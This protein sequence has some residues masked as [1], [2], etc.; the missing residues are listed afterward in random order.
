MHKS[1]TVTTVLAAAPFRTAD[2]A[3]LQAAADGYR[4]IFSTE[5]DAAQLAQAEVILGDVPPALLQQAP[6]LQWLQLTSAGT[7]AWTQTGSLPPEVLLTNVS[8]AFGQA[9]SEYVLALI[10]ML[11]KKLHLYR[12]SQSRGIWQDLGPQASPVGKRVLIAGAGDIGC[13]VARILK[14]FA[15]HTVGIRRVPRALPPEFDEMDTLEGLDRQLPLADI[16]VCALPNTPQ[17]RGLFDRRRLA[18]LRPEALL[19]NVG[20]G[21]LIDCDAL[22]EQLEAGALAGAALDVTSPEPL[23]P[24]HPLWRCP[25]CIITPHITGGSFGH[26][27]VTSDI[28]CEICC[29]NL[30]HFAA[31]EPLRNPVDRQTGYRVTQT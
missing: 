2:R 29:E 4:F 13:A 1:G 21:N 20:R 6:R 24:A 10:L 26:L 25:N 17:T 3:A 7:D 27:E 18:L 9:I 22:A 15:C 28:I 30:R 19:L 12:D 5:P 11:Q 23:P 8:G 31:G 16:V 14:P